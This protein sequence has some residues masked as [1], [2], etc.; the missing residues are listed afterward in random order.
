MVLYVKGTS[1]RAANG[2]G[3]EAGALVIYVQTAIRALTI[4]QSAVADGSEN[5]KNARAFA[6]RTMALMPNPTKMPAKT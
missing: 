4:S 2:L 6:G 3:S 5:S 1:A